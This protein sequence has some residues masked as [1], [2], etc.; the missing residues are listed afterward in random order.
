VFDLPSPP[1]S[2]ASLDTLHRWSAEVRLPCEPT[3][4]FP[5]EAEQ[6]S[7]ITQ[8]DADFS[9]Q[10]DGGAPRGLSDSILLCRQ[11]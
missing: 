1:F 5:R 9:G 8:A 11:S 6:L 2:T 3:N 7:R 10:R 4:S